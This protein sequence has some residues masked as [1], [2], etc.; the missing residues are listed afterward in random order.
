MQ[1]TPEGLAAIVREEGFKPSWYLCPAGKKTIGVGHVILPAEEKTYCAPGFKLTRL[2]GMV[3]LQ[4]DVSERFA[5]P[6]VKYCTRPCT[7]NQL[8]AL[9]SF[10][11]N[12]GPGG[13]KASSL[14]KLHNAGHAAPEEITRAFGL[15]NKFTNPETGQ[16]E[17]SNGLTLRRARE[18]ALYLT[19]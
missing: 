2:Q 14:L 7:P 5:P 18:A 16:K 17:V 12:T 11:F 19:P 13:L 10:C 1:L 4:K 6:V 8:A 15:W 9:V 3:L